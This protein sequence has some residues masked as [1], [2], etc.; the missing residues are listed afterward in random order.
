MQTTPADPIDKLLERIVKEADEPIPNYATFLQR[1]F[2]RLIDTAIVLGISFA[3]F[4]SSK[5]F[6][7]NDTGFESDFV[8]AQLSNFVYAFALILWSL[9]YSPLLEATGGTLGKRIMRI[10]IVDPKNLQTP[11]FRNCMTRSIIYLV[12]FALIVVPS[13]LSCLAI[14]I[15][16]EKQTWHDKLGDVICVKR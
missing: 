14:F 12:L 16:D 2:A 1:V 11:Q 6:I 15:S 5:N 10:K 7:K 9:F 13:I 8:I 3:V 4:Q